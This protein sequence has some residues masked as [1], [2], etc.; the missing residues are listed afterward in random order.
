MNTAARDA[1]RRI[2]RERGSDVE[3]D[4]RLC[5]ALLADHNPGSRL[6]N[7]VLSH[8]VREGVPEGLLRSQSALPLEVRM[9]LL[10]RRL[11]ENLGLDPSVAAWTG[12]SWANSRPHSLLKRIS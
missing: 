5:A 2:V 7:H 4:P 8:A 9:A 11:V 3:S 1:L 12:E 6:E 10:A